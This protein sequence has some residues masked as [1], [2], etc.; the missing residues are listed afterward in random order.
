MN[1]FIHLTIELTALQVKKDVSG[2]YQNAL[3]LGDVYERIRALRAAGQH[4]L[5]YLTAVTHGLEEQAEEITQISGIDTSAIKP[6][7]QAQ[8]LKPP[9]P[10]QPLK[11]NWPLLHVSKG[12][13]H[14]STVFKLNHVYSRVKVGSLFQNANGTIRFS[15]YY[16]A[17]S[18]KPMHLNQCVSDSQLQ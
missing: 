17:I 10:I 11:E 8:L 6:L 3:M 16:Y 18:Y 4:S 1:A 7:P 15:Y 5:A 12:I 2:M 13:F 9:P 14:V